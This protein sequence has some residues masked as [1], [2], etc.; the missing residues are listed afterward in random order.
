MDCA[1]RFTEEYYYYSII[2]FEVSIWDSLK[3]T[4]AINKQMQ[5]IIGST[6]PKSHF[7][8]QSSNS[9]NSKSTNLYSKKVMAN[10]SKR[11]IQ[12]YTRFHFDLV[13]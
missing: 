1:H 4:V 3:K 5:K 13:H 11:P 7:P 12:N 9:N 6:G 2:V 8:C 10:G